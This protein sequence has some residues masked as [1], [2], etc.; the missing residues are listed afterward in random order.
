MGGLALAK[1]GYDKYVRFVLPLLGI[2][3]LL[4][5]GFLTLGALV[6]GEFA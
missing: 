2:L 5:C 3:F 1:V 6:G 4:T